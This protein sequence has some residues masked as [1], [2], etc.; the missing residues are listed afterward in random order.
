MGDS[1]RV[2]S[3]SSLPVHRGLPCVRDEPKSLGI[4]HVY[5]TRSTPYTVVDKRLRSKRGISNLYDY[6]LY[7]VDKVL[8]AGG[9]LRSVRR[10]SV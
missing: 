3:S 2:V 7:S 4:Y 9:I 10:Y 5:A 1:A 6:L 8:L